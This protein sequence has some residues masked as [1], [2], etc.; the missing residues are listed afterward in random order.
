LRLLATRPESGCAVNHYS[1][2]GDP[3]VSDESSP[4][5][6]SAGFSLDVVGVG[7]LNVDY[8]AHRT[9][10]SDETASRLRSRIADLVGDLDWGTEHLVDAATIHA[11]I[12][13]IGSVAA[14]AAVGGSAFNAIQA[15]AATGMGVRLGYVGVAGQVPLAADSIMRQFDAAGIDRRYVHRD[16]GSLCGICLS[17]SESGDR[18]LLTHVG[19]NRGMADYLR[20]EFTGTVGY[21]AAARMV[22]VTSFLDDRS[23]DGLLS[24]LRE[25]RRRSPTTRVCFDPGHVWSLDRGR[26][27][28]GILHLS[29]YLLVNPREFAELGRCRDGEPDQQVAG[30]LLARMGGRGVVV[31]KQPHGTATYHSH[32]SA[33]VYGLHP[34]MPLRDE[35]TLDNTGAGDVF[36]AGLLTVLAGDQPSLARGC[37]LGMRLA[38]HTLGH[39]A[40]TGHHAFGQITRD[41]GQPGAPPGTDRSP[42]ADGHHKPF[43]TAAT[44][45]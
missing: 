1:P 14:Q 12:D 27:V 11:A 2:S 30:R 37:V 6:V 29:D 5:A 43:P 20:D 4:G 13:A 23:A 38:R 34:Q 10:D 33:T 32:R 44:P 36:A 35:E 18:T 39:L 21:L 28:E 41:F 40:T 31:V 16:E 22:H 9:T 26:A 17:Y 8:I 3:D 42:T 7:A 45:P 24:V 15:I 19:A 25:V